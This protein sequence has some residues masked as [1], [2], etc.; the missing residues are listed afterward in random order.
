MAVEQNGELLRYINRPSE[1]VVLRAIEQ[2]PLAIRFVD[3]PSSK[4]I[5]TAISST[6]KGI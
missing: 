4:V 2:N 3:K 1:N 6:I 5:L